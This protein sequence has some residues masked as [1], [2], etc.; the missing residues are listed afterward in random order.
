MNL[1]NAVKK[2]LMVNEKFGFEI[3]AVGS[4]VKKALYDKKNDVKA[5]HIYAGRLIMDIM[6]TSISFNFFIIS[7]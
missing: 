6:Q 4:H 7:L 2:N 1:V 5:N 3:T